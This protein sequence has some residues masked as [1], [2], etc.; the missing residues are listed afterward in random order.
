MTTRRRRVL[1]GL[2]T[3]LLTVTLLP[4][5]RPMPSTTTESVRGQTEVKTEKLSGTVVEVEGN[6]L[7]VRLLGGALRTFIVPESR[8]FVVDGK[9]LSVHE[10]KPNTT[11]TAT[12][13][14][15]ITPV[16]DRTT[17]IGSGKVFFVSGN[18]VIL[19]LPNN[20]N[21]MYKV[22][23]SYRFIVGG[24]PATVHDL[25]KGM[26]ISASKIVESP[27]TEF[28]SNTVV[29]GHAPPQPKLA[30]VPTPAVAQTRP[31]PQPAAAPEPA[32][33]TPI[34]P[35]PQPA[36]APIR[37]VAESHAPAALPR[38][39]SSVPFIG[40]M[41]VLLGCASLAIRRLRRSL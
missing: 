37:E 8:R 34:A 41:G 11:L 13:T 31:V 36:A 23:E 30:E 15:T 10:L 1:T 38:T 17:T 21:R 40:M 2:G 20:E 29:E 3:A 27:R 16:I 5:Q 24:Q 18:T 25:R 12:V 22:E 28:A 7:V 14:T 19:T 6:E 9:E 35:A 26:N 33:A 32:P 4:G 39:G